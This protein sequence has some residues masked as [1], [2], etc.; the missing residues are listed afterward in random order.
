MRLFSHRFRFL[1]YNA[2][3][4]FAD[5]ADLLETFVT[6]YN[7]IFI[8]EQPHSKEIRHSR[9]AVDPAGAPVAGGPLHP[10]WMC[11]HGPDRSGPVSCCGVHSSVRFI[12]P[13]MSQL[14][15]VT[16]SHPDILFFS[17]TR[18]KDQC[19]EHF[20]NIYW[21]PLSGVPLI[22]LLQVLPLIGLS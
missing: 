2:Q 16:F 17:L 19:V 7:I 20:I 3:R 21:H 12:W 18:P 8:Q 15:S 9:D 11:L 4:S 5:V 10:Q 1:F 22:N 13:S 14:T 6:S